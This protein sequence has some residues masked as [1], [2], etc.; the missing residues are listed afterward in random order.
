MLIFAVRNGTMLASLD[1]LSLPLVVSVLIGEKLS[2][3]FSKF[4][5]KKLAYQVLAPNQ[6]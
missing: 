6:A 4:D 2:S 3:P 1:E 5:S